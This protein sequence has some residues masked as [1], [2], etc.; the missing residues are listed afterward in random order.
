MAPATLI[1]TGP[2]AISGVTDSGTERRAIRRLDVNIT[3]AP[4]AWPYAGQRISGRPAPRPHLAESVHR[5]VF[6]TRPHGAHKRS[7]AS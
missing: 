3:G 4:R 6:V 1:E 5:S 7:V 2:H